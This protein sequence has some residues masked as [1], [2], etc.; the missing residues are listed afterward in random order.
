MRIVE[1]KLNTLEWEIL[2]YL[3]EYCVGKNN[4]VKGWILAKSFNITEVSLRTHLSKIKKHQEVIIGSDK[5]L[6]YYIPL[7][8][9]KDEALAYSQNKALGH[10]KNAV[11]QNPTFALKAYKLLNE[12]LKKAPKE[13]QNQIRMKLTGHETETVNYYGDK[14]LKGGKDEEENE[15]L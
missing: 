7:E 2:D 6:G 13:V 9:E 3:K 11:M 15:G 12:T 14:Y 10:L 4:A 8:S 5:K 1:N